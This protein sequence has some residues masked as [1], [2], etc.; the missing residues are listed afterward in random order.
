MN[1]GAASDVFGNG[2]ILLSCL[3]LSRRL[4]VEFRNRMRL[5]NTRRGLTGARLASSDLSSSSEL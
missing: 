5:A 2:S 3:T 1:L 4:D